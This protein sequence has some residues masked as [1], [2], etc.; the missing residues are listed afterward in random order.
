MTTYARR[1]AGAAWTSPTYSSPVV[2]VAEGWPAAKEQEFDAVCGQFWERLLQIPGFNLLRRYPERV[3][4]WSLFSPSPAEGAGPVAQASPAGA[5]WDGTKLQLDQPRVLDYLQQ[6][7][8]AS[9]DGYGQYALSTLV[10]GYE[11]S[12]AGVVAFLLP[13][14]SGGAPFTAEYD[15]VQP[16]ASVPLTEQF[17]WV[18]TTVDADWERVVARAL[19]RS[20]GLGD[21]WSDPGPDFAAPAPAPVPGQDRPF[22]RSEVNLVSGPPPTTAP[23]PS[24]PWFREL[25][26]RGRS[27][28]LTVVPTGQ[29]SPTPNEP[30]QLFEGGGW[31]RTGVYRSAADCFMR[32]RIG[33]PAN[34]PRMD[35]VPFCVLCQRAL[36][37]T[38]AGTAGRRSRISLGRQRSKFDEI[39]TWASVE[40]PTMPAQVSLNARTAPGPYWT[41]TARTG[42]DVGGLQIEDLRLL[43][44]GEESLAE[45]TVAERI[46]FRDIAVEFDDGTKATF[47]VA[48]ALASTTT[49]PVLLVGTDG[50]VSPTDKHYPYGVKLTLTDDFDGKCPVQVDMSLVVRG[51]GADIDPS[52]GLYACKF[53]PQLTLRW[54]PGGSTG[55]KKF[56]GCVRVV[57][58]NAVKA[59]DMGGGS[60]MGGHDMGGATSPTTVVSF[61]CDTNRIFDKLKRRRA[62]VHYLF[63]VAPL[64]F[65][66][67]WLIFDYHK[68]DF[69]VDTEIRAVAG[70]A[71]PPA[72]RAIRSTSLMWPAGTTYE[73]GT[74]RESD[75]G[76][77]DNVHIHGSMGVD[78]YDP[79]TPKQPMV[80]AP[81]CAEACVH[82]HW[83][84]GYLGPP[85]A[86]PTPDV[87]TK[88]FQGW[89]RRP[90]LFGG[91]AS[92]AHS[93]YATPLIPPN[94]D[95]VVAVTHPD[96][97]RTDPWRP[98][99]Q[100]SRSLEG[101]RKAVWYTA[102]VTSPEREA[103]QVLLEFGI[104][105]AYR[106][107]YA[108]MLNRV[109]LAWVRL[110]TADPTGTDA[111][112]DSQIQH[113]LYSLIR[114]YLDPTFH[115][116]SAQIPE[117]T[118]V[119]AN[120]HA[121]ED[122]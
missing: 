9:D 118:V 85:G 55:V 39:G 46:D 27:R 110:L 30:I 48:K 97:D 61:F 15:S 53:F 29:Q 4:V 94:Q 18:A 23:D 79:R 50:Q 14:V 112:S 77:Y 81:G 101:R 60:D 72:Q 66:M 25:D 54:L 33:D 1:I 43:D 82:I 115:A 68:P 44:Q 42:A 20:F 41:F 31:Y 88:A 8:V 78:P 17:R 109:N 105:F 91:S 111:R 89:T 116:T 19:A 16:Q 56:R 11:A 100:A 84:W 87:E 113:L 5:T 95:L 59:H 67:W 51:E 22:A 103:A 69:R 114:W 13:P 52:G 3:S 12:N 58:N 73:D 121:L 83:R 35:D 70:P 120:G 90:G 38:I 80:H 108:A 71:T 62:L 10:H 74:E 122:L 2:L 6:N 7:A 65:P 45:E 92:E 28:P 21:E 37:R 99:V 36:T 64:G 96:T 102:D 117:G 76:Q 104:S 24:F 106:Y 119:G 98:V 86:I 107:N 63:D 47:D 34:T 93:E 26:A 75:Q 49:P 57:L 32:R 40:R